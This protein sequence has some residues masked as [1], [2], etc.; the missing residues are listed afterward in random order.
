MTTGTALTPGTSA[1]AARLTRTP[2]LGI[3]LIAVAA[4]GVEMAVSARY[5]YARDELYFLAAGQHLAFGYV[6]Q[7]PLTPLLA[8]ISSM[9]TGHTLVGLRLLPALGLAGRVRSRRVLARRGGPRRVSHVVRLRAWPP[10]VVLAGAWPSWSCSW[11]HRPDPGCP[12]ASSAGAIS[13]APLRA[14]E[15]WPTAPVSPS[16]V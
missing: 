6:D 15:R 2:W 11:Q 16:A 8:R 7:P 4:F 14:G 5:G 10:R 1:P 3:A 9:A 13:P 12:R